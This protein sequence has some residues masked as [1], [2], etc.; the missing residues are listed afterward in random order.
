MQKNM[1]VLDQV[2]FYQLYNQNQ[3]YKG[4]SYFVK[5]NQMCSDDKC[6]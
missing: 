6:N 2:L 4:G 5:L 1:E 3:S